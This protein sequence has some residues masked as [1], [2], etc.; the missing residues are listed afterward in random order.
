L[1]ASLALRN[2]GG[3][4]EKRTR[5]AKVKKRERATG[6]K[7]T[8]GKREREPLY[9]KNRVPRARMRFQKGVHPYGVAPGLSVRKKGG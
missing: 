7:R 1:R 2:E 3:Y 4:A 9:E 5:V 8:E 6:D